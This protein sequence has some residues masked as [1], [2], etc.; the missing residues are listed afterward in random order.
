MDFVNSCHH[1]GAIFATL[2]GRYLSVEASR[3]FI[4]SEGGAFSVSEV[5]DGL[6]LIPLLFSGTT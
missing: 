6:Y 1:P 3:T 4:V 5:V 2:G